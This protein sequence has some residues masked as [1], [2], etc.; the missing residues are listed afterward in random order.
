MDPTVNIARLLSPEEAQRAEVEYSDLYNRLEE[1][2]GL[3]DP[4]V[5]SATKKSKANPP[6]SMQHSFILETVQV[7]M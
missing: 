1:K 3:G 4:S 7:D 2:L 6:V 5:V